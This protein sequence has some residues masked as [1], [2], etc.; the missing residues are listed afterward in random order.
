VKGKNYYDSVTL[1]F[2]VTEEEFSD[3][4]VIAKGSRIELF[5]KEHMQIVAGVSKPT[6]GSV[7]HLHNP[8]NRNY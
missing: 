2:E 5:S 3:H 4:V 6:G 1:S 7:Q 8:Q